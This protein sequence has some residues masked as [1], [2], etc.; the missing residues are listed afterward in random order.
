[1]RD[2]RVE[3]LLTLFDC[4]VKA[5]L[6]GSTMRNFLPKP[7]KGKTV[8]IGAGKAAA[9]MA[10]TLEQIWPAELSGC[11][12]TRYG[13]SVATHRITVLEASHPVPDQASIHAAQVM[14][15]LVQGLTQDD[16]V[17]ALIS[18]GA[19]SLMVEPIQGLSLEQKQLIHRDLLRSG[20]KISE[21][22]VVRKQL[23]GIKGGQLAQACYP[24]PVVN[25]IISDVPGDDPS[26]IGSGPTV[27]DESTPIHALEILIR[28]GLVGHS[29]AIRL[30][31]ESA[32]KPSKKVLL[33][34]IDTHIIASPQ[35]ALEAAALQAQKLGYHPLILSDSI[36]GEAREVALV[37]AAI[38]QQV[39][40][41]NQPLSAPCVLLSGGETTVTVKGQ[42]RGGRNAE[43]LL[44]LGLALGSQEGVYALAAD[45]DGV[46][47]TEDNAG[48]W[49]TPETWERAQS[50][51]LNLR[52]FL[53][54]NDGYGFFEAV[55]QLYKTGPTLTN[56]ND[57]RAIIVTKS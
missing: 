50:L 23:S 29:D 16:L 37:H 18:G 10:Q 26:L 21:M 6:P 40:R 5:A 22:N 20:A 36:E 14:R 45:T 43:F 3:H 47:G 24:A 13:H 57:F 54:N 27:V 49:W 25:L 15:G 12:V 55:D 56:V 52:Q 48:V 39:I 32:Q 31:Q 1:M 42:G 4:A 2:R 35:L 53:D 17:I 38:A 30:L 8:V 46:D 11:V 41:H 44:S 28:Y 9:L 51:G 34:T 33:P 7:P 19:S